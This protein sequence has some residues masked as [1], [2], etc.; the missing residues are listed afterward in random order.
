MKRVRTDAYSISLGSAEQDDPNSSPLLQPRPRS[1]CRFFLPAAYEPQ[2]RYP[3]VVWL[4][5]NGSNESQV[6]QVMPHVSDQNYVAVGVRGIYSDETAQRGFAWDVSA[7]GLAL[8]EEAVL[9][10]VDQASERFA[11]H[12]ER[13]FVGGYRDG[14]TV[15]LQL[16]L[17]NPKRFVGAFSLLGRFPHTEAPLAHLEAARQLPM[18][19]AM[20]DNSSSYGVDQLCAD[21]RTL[22]AARMALEVRHYLGDDALCTAM[23]RDVNGWLMS[24]VT[25]CRLPEASASTADPTAV[26]SSN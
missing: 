12:P 20:A 1:H 17:Q 9:D 25:G 10:A 18:L 13:I 8:A 26:F 7:A 19:L 24:Y 6:A 14:G 4:H 3:L 2:Y 22:H 16:A 5:D 11:V 23:L 15:A 21:L